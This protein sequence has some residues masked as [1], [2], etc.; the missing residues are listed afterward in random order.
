M[1]EDLQETTVLEQK[2]TGKSGRRWDKSCSLGSHHPV[3]L[4]TWYEDQIFHFW[5]D[6]SKITYFEKKTTLQNH[7]TQ[8]LSNSF[9]WSRWNYKTEI[10][11]EFQI[12]LLSL[13]S[14]FSSFHFSFLH[15]SPS[16]PSSPAPSSTHYVSE[17]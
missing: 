11:G 5:F 12:Q 14:S 2:W 10:R 9:A 3:P 1:L 7:K 16:S 17:D 13:L 4:R 6:K 15:P 8:T